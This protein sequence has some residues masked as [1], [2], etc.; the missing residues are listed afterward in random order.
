M[1]AI[2]PPNQAHQ[3]PPQEILMQMITSAWVSQ[4]IYVAAKVGVADL[5]K[6]G[7]KSASEL[8]KSLNVN[9]D[10]IID[11]GKLLVIE[12]VIP[13]A[14][15]PSIGKFLDIEMLLMTS[16]GRERTAEEFQELFAKGGF[17]LTN[18]IPTPSPISIIEGIKK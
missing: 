11:N 10:A 5:L 3:L 16:G 4:S 17:E 1:S 9:A 2:Q 6:D 12:T 8:A 15:Q 7:S 14:N 13:G 18:I